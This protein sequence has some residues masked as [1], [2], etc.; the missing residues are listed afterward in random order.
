MSRR[1]RA[2]LIALRHAGAELLDPVPIDQMTEAEHLMHEAALNIP[3]EVGARFET[4]DKLSDED[5]QTIVEIMR[6]SLARFQPK[7]EAKPQT[8]P[9]A[10][11]E[12]KPA[13]KAHAEPDRKSD[14]GSKPDTSLDAKPKPETE[15]KP[16]P[17]AMEKS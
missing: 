14:G 12:T 17:E 9:I 15:P 1:E 4:A 11:P 2:H 3:A 7:P 5:R 6:K 16:E 8:A 10:A 13:G